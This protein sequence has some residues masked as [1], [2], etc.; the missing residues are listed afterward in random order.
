MQAIQIKAFGGVDTFEM[1][2]QNKPTL[3]PKQVL[4]KNVAVAIDPYD[5]KFVMGLMGEA[6][7]LP[8]IPGSSVVG[9]IV[10]VGDAVTDF[11]IGDRV[12]ATRHL[13]TYAEYVPVGQSALAKVPDGLDNVI[14]VAA[15]L[16][17]ATGYQM[18]VRDLAVEA[19]QKILIQGGAGQVGAM[20][21]QVALNR[22][23]EVYATASPVDFDY[24]KS[25]GSVVPVDYHTAYE[26]ELHDFDGVLDTIGGDVA[27]QSAEILKPGGKLRNLTTIPANIQQ[28]DIDVQHTYLEGR[29]ELLQS[30]L[31]D[32]AA[33]RVTIRIGEI[34]PFNRENMMAVHARARQK[35]L[36]GKT[37]LTW[38]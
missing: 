31:N 27:R 17:A 28:Y 7:K 11:Q 1:V 10:A 3:K 38:F 36:V 24:L 15:V 22:G 2:E 14:A 6:D 34:L 35:S 13:Q 30:L 32:L 18:I 33:Q 29:G 8:L 21:V 9:E 26:K 16:G 25:L 23:A 4:I 5:V 20:A 12:A 19:G 37:I